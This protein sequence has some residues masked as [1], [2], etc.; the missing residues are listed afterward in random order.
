LRLG[1]HIVSDFTA[2]SIG[3]RRALLV[4]P[5]A[6]AALTILGHILWVLADSARDAITITTVITF[7]AASASHAWITRGGLWTAGYLIISLGLGLLVEAIGRST[8]FPFGEYDYTDSLG[9]KLLGVPLVIPL[10]WAMMAY[11]ALLAAQRL[12]HSRI[13]VTILGAW[14]LATWDVFLDSQMVSE[15]HWVWADPTPALWGVPGIPVG[16]YLGWLLTALVMIGLMS[17]L[18][19]RQSRHDGVPTLLLAWV[20]LS[21]ILANAVFFGRPAVALWGG[22]LMGLV[23]VP[24]AWRSWSLRDHPTSPSSIRTH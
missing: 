16:N 5:W 15:G 22:I 19:A 24:W 18:P 1:S 11:P 10:A 23:V 21:N 17:L 12:T 4:I 7:F 3:T 8:G 13:G 2:R 9:V 14:L 20:Y 6:F